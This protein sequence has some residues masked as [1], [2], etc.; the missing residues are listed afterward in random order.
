MTKALPARLGSGLEKTLVDF[1]LSPHRHV[2][3]VTSVCSYSR[4]V[5]DS[6][7]LAGSSLTSF[8]QP[9]YPP[10]PVSFH[11]LASI[12]DSPLKFDPRLL[13][14]YNSH[15]LLPDTRKGKEGRF[16]EIVPAAGGQ[17]ANAVAPP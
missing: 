5:A 4:K 13:M 7:S 16:S 3:P 11:Q 10:A 17:F 8:D 6:V 9:S 14:L 15:P 12:L 1:I 2:P